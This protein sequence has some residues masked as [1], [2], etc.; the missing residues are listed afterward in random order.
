MKSPAK[1]GDGIACAC[2]RGWKLPS[3]LGISAWPELCPICQGYGEITRAELAR[4]TGVD[5]RTIAR[6]DGLR[7]K[8]TTAA[9]VVDVLAGI[10]EKVGK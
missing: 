1:K 2:V 10:L 5:P 7:S 4:I 9:K 6:L 3:S 8:A